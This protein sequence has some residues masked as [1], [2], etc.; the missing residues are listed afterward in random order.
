MLH[1]CHFNKTVLNP[2]KRSGYIGEGRIA[3]LTLK[4]QILDEVLL[5][6]TK[7]TRADDIQLPPRIVRVAAGRLDEREEDFYQ[8]LVRTFLLLIIPYSIIS[9]NTF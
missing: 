5:R 6:R 4:N 3:M 8:A 1:F 7:T 9:T 2:I